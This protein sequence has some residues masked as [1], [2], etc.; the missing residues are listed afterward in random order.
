M[1]S[2]LRRRIDDDLGSSIAT[3]RGPARPRGEARQRFAPL[4]K[5]TLSEAP[6]VPIATSVVAGSTSM[7][8]PHRCES[9]VPWAQVIC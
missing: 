4:A 8:R 9:A 7:R 3:K 2:L 5:V 6:A 1:Q